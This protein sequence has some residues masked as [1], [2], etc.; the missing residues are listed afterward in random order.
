MKVAGLVLDGISL[1]IVALQCFKTGKSLSDL[2]RKRKRHIETLIRALK[3]YSGYLELLLEWLLTRLKKDN[4]VRDT[5]HR[6]LSTLLQDAETIESLRQLLERNP[7]HAFQN[8][9]E[10]D[11]R[12]VVNIV[13]NINDLVP[14]DQVNICHYSN[15]R[16]KRLLIITGPN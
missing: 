10:N 3:G 2:I 1:V 6:S 12:A 5:D 4:A 15:S 14:A 9:V 7:S 13:T 8:A 11:E 16:R